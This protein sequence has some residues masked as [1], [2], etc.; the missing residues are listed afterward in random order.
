M[1]LG[2]N[3]PVHS[4]TI[5]ESRGGRQSKEHTAG[6]LGGASVGIQSEDEE[7]DYTTSSE[8]FLTKSL[9]FSL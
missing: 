9:I 8:I 2:L 1:V 6:K 3:S 4:H 7:Q 5:S